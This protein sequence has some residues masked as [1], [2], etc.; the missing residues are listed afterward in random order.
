MTREEH[1]LWAKKRALEYWVRG[2]YMQAVTS[3][4]SDLSKHEELKNHTGLKIGTMWFLAPAMHQDRDFVKRF[5]DGF[6]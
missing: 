6:R 2:D 1:L 5:I 4:M 3:L